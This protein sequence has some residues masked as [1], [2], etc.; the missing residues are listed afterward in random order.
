MLTRWLL[1]LLEVILYKADHERGFADCGLLVEEED[2]EK[3]SQVVVFIC[4]VSLQ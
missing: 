1:V 3:S 2:S 4:D